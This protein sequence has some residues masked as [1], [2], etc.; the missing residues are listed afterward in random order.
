M[1]SPCVM[2]GHRWCC[3]MTNRRKKIRKINQLVFCARPVYTL[4]KL[5]QIKWVVSIESN[6]VSSPCHRIVRDSALKMKHA[7]AHHA[8]VYICLFS[9]SYHSLAYTFRTPNTP[10]SGALVNRVASDVSCAYGIWIYSVRSTNAFGQKCVIISIF[11]LRRMRMLLYIWSYVA[12]LSK[13]KCD[14]FF[15]WLWQHWKE[16]P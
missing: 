10:V 14:R 12:Y 7:N 15:G 16:K 6:C 11:V 4:R 3:R 2:C 1:L 13:E 5:S 9:E 8:C